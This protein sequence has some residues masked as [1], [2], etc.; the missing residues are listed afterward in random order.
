MKKPLFLIVLMIIVLIL[1]GCS[2]DKANSEKVSR[3]HEKLQNAEAISIKADV[4]ADYGGRVYEYTLSYTESGGEGVVEILSP[5]NVAGIKARI[6]EEGASI[7]YHGV[8][9]GLGDLSS[10]GLSPVSALPTIISS[11]K[12]G[13]L[14]SV[15]REKDGD[16]ELLLLDI[17]ISD[18]SMQQLWLDAGGLIPLK[19]EI[20]SGNSVVIFCNILEWAV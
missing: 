14:E 19:S 1:P 18:D 12:N 11:I 20:R 9:L 5:D 16:T 15:S 13:H 7:E 6:T 3:F 4:S 10:G 2:E 8:S 17:T